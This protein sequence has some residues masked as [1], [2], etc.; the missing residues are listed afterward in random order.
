MYRVNASRLAQ[1]AGYG[2]EVAVE[3]RPYRRIKDERTVL[4]AEN[5]MNEDTGQRLRHAEEH[6]SGLQP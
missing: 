2:G 5:D 1:I 4:G 6:K 3:C